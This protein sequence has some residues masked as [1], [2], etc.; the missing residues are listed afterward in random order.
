MSLLPLTLDYFYHRPVHNADR[1]TVAHLW[2]EI[3]L[4]PQFRIC[5]CRRHSLPNPVGTGDAEVQA[6]QVSSVINLV[7]KMEM[8]VWQKYWRYEVATENK[9]FSTDDLVI[10]QDTYPPG[11]SRTERL[12]TNLQ[13]FPS[14]YVHPSS[15]T[16]T[17]GLW[18]LLCSWSTPLWQASY[19]WPHTIPLR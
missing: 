12:F 7:M 4:Q 17:H 18:L 10:C 19:V 3:L 14:S 2:P 1:L 15:R 11:V 13:V 5:G 9:Y 16:F 8:E 6:M